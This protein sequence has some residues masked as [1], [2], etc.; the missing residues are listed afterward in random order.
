MRK[1]AAV[2]VTHDRKEKLLR[3]IDAVRM[4]TAPEKADIIVVDNNSG[5]GTGDAVRSY[6]KKVKEEAGTEAGSTGAD[7]C[8]GD[9]LYFDLG[10]NSG[11]AGGFS[12]GIRK[13]A[14][15]G[16]DYMWLMDDDCIPADDALEH[17]LRFDD[18]NQ[19]EY[20][21]LSGRALWEDGSLCR[22]NVQRGTLTG[23]VSLDTEEPVRAV[24]ASFVSLFIPSYA[25]YDMGLPLREFFIWTDD[26]EYT[27]RISNKYPCWVIPRSVVIH[28]CDANSGA[29]IS[30]A[31]D[32]RIGRFRYLYR[33]DVYLYRREGLRGF[34]YEAARLPVHAARIAFSRNSIKEKSGASG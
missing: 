22:M 17:F 21:F 15:A 5:D 10:Y 20:G 3:C 34:A 27:R 11:G 16:Y 26:W 12:W 7:K 8:G 30:S 32:D 19:G 28:D 25:V 13:A 9:I 4:Q 18:T 6:I 31:E 29:D 14:E 2:I 33:N 23:K 24:M 1:I